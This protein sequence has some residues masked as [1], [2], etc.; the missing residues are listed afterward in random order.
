MTKY[1]TKIQTK[2]KSIKTNIKSTIK[3]TKNFKNTKI[4]KKTKEKL[5]EEKEKREH[6][7]QERLNQEQL[8]KKQKEQDK[9][10][11]KFKEIK[12]RLQKIRDYFVQVSKETTMYAFLNNSEYKHFILRMIQRIYEPS[13]VKSRNFKNILSK[14]VKNQQD[15]VF[16]DL[17][18]GELQNYK[19]GFIF[20]EFIDFLSDFD[21]ACE[22]WYKERN[23][24]MYYI[25][26]KGRIGISFDDGMHP[27]I[28]TL[29]MLENMIK[30]SQI[31][32]CFKYSFEKDYMVKKDHFLL[33]SLPP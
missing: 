31:K 15:H 13:D 23:N 18:E 25:I 14:Q 6:A 5:Q 1:A 30:K 33:P 24:K 26:F 16:L 10:L 21:D 9:Y 7:E 4:P 3:K 11:Q 8:Q 29:H 27:T 19:M 22:L 2:K 17:I 32:K 28:F 20:N 12:E